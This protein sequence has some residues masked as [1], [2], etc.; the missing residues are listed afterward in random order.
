MIQI[1]LLIVAIRAFLRKPKLKALRAEQ[2]GAPED[3]FCE[4]RELELKSNNILLW[5][6]AGLMVASIAVQILA[7]VAFPDAMFEVQ[8]AFFVLF[9]ILLTMSAIQGSK[10]AKIKKQF[11]IKWP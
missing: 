11:N 2:F 6:T 8:I 1:I 5:A 9:F 3:K 10:A 7:A 4:W